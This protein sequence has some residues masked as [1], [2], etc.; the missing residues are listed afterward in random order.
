MAGLAGLAQGDGLGLERIQIAAIDHLIELDGLSHDMQ[1]A[2]DERRD[3]YLQAQGYTILRFSNDELKTNLDGVV[4]T[5]LHR[6]T[7]LLTAR[8]PLT[9][10]N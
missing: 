7:T 2:H 10:K 9:S 5:I 8:H 4:R 6:A 1:I 3:A